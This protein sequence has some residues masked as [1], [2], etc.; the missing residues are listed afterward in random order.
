MVGGAHDDGRRKDGAK[1]TQ[2]TF[3]KKKK[4]L[5]QASF[6]FLSSLFSS[7]VTE[8]RG[9]WSI[10]PR[11]HS[12]GEEKLFPS[13]NQKKVPEIFV[14]GQ[15]RQ[16]LFPLHFFFPFFE[17]WSWKLF[18]LAHILLLSDMHARLP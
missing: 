16:C 18:F 4:L 15:T 10:S 14:T 6:F 5:G 2:T 3:A 7:F 1:I 8:L 13:P 17:I 12:W 11:F 9:W